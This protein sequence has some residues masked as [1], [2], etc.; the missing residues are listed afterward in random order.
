MKKTL[1]EKASSEIKSFNIT[2]HRMVENIRTNGKIESPCKIT[3]V[4]GLQNG[5]KTA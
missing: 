2:Y 3:F 1:I 4:S 5:L